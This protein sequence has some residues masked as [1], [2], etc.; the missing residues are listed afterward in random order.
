MWVGGKSMI[1]LP[2]T[3]VEMELNEVGKCAK[4]YYD[5]HHSL[6]VILLD[7]KKKTWTIAHGS[8]YNTA[9]VCGRT[10]GY[11]LTACHVCY[12]L[13]MLGLWTKGQSEAFR[14]QQW[15]EDKRVSE[16]A[17]IKEAIKVLQGLGLVVKEKEKEK[18]PIPFLVDF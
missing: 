8:P 9:S 18:E 15:N 2:G 12:A 16:Q 7:A 13:Y 5:R 11:S 6:C 3:F 4:F 1:E 10:N 17:K 14:E